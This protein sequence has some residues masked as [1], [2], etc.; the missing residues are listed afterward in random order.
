ME[1]KDVIK[2]RKDSMGSRYG[3]PPTVDG[4]YDERKNRLGL[5]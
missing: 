4:R 1:W 3:V 5:D 2:L